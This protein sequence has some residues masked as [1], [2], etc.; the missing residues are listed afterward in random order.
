MYVNGKI[1]PAENIQEIGG[2]HRKMVERVKS[3]MIHLIKF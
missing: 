2:R 3:S 1:R